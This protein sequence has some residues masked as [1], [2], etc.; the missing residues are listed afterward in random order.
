MLIDNRLLMME[1]FQHKVA[2]LV[3]CCSCCLLSIAQPTLVT[4]LDNRKILIGEQIRLKIEA[5]LPQ[6]DFYVRWINW[7]DSMPHFELVGKS[8]VDSIYTRERLTSLV[9][10]FTLTSFDSG[11]WVIPA[12]DINFNPVSGDSSQTLL[13]DSF[14]VSV[15]YAKDTTNTTRD[16]KPIRDAAYELPLWY[17]LAG[18]AVVLLLIA[19]GIWIFLQAKKVKKAVPTQKGL[20]AYQQA[21]NGLDATEKLSLTDPAI[22][23]TYHT[24]LAGILKQY[25]SQK[26]GIDLS[27]CT[28]SD[29]LVLFSREGMSKDQISRVSSALRCGNA[30][31][32]ARFIP[33]QEDNKLSL[34]AVRETI[35]FIEHLFNQ[36]K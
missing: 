32:F 26:K 6:Q 24:N 9:Q 18:G 5:R 12:L 8:K 31:K 22:V 10:T 23:K 16:I 33:E 3:M 11:T 7:P 20:S 4:S 29:L 28:T 2:L 30:V 35:D 13:S 19:T 15:T 17:W 27:S 36:Q 1:I 14:T 25:L 34:A 21:M